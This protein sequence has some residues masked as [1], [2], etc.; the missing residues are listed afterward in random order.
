MSTSEPMHVNQVLGQ[1]EEAKVMRNIEY[2]ENALMEAK[3]SLIDVYQ[4]FGRKR[5]AEAEGS[6]ETN[7]KGSPDTNA[8]KKDKKDCPSV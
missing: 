8:N 7:A 2:L 3:H 6:L 5:P 1:R 4:K